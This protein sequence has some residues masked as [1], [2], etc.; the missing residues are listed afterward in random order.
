MAIQEIEIQDS[1]GLREQLN[2]EAIV[3]IER[4]GRIGEAPLIMFWDDAVAPV[5]TEQEIE[6][7]Q[8]NAQ[9]GRLDNYARRLARDKRRVTLGAENGIDDDVLQSEFLSLQG[10]AAS[11]IR[12]EAEGRSKA[13]ESEELDLLETQADALEAIDVALT[14]VRSKVAD[15]TYTTEAGIDNASEW[16]QRGG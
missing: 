2:A 9:K 16:P 4:K 11:K 5:P 1:T 7:M 6:D 13:G 3:S 14:A 10:R 12:R 8:T 15:G